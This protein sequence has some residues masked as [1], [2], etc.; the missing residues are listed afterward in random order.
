MAKI[1]YSLAGEG[2]GHATR[3]KAVIEELEKKHEVAIACGG[4]AYH[5]MAEYFKDVMYIQD[6]QMGYKDNQVN[7]WDT[8]MK[9]LCN[10]PSHIRSFID[11]KKKIKIFKPEII[12]N[13][14]EFHTNYLSLLLNIPNIIIDNEQ[15]IAKT[16][17]EF[18][19]SLWLDFFK[20]W[21]VVKFI[22]PKADY[23][24]ISSFFFPELKDKKASYCSPLIRKKI[25]DAKP[26]SGKKILVYQTSDTNSRLISSLKR[27]DKDFIVYG[28]NIDKTDKNIIYR[29]F[30]EDGFIKDLAECR[31]VIINGG[32]CVM[33][34]A[35]FL[36]KPILS[37]PI[38][39][40]FEQIINS[41][42]LD[43]LGL[44]M[45]SKSANKKVIKEF[46]QRIPEFKNR[47]G[48]HFK[49]HHSKNNHSTFFIELEHKI[50]EM[51]KSS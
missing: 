5:Y 24:F 47:L 13:D 40:Q 19:P 39:K 34:E 41:I 15:I 22:V 36:K 1:L 17:L 42:Y 37:I 11:L 18:S 45:N 21:I 20:S 29:Q 43:K 16:D 25:R 27:I 8:F 31:G 46:I 50:K 3:S 51:I 35:L 2:M 48:N 23:R 44:G 30:D 49:N 28:F 32:F 38:E 26:K 7:S 4:K 9:N 10:I 6:F 14:F 12:I 33:S